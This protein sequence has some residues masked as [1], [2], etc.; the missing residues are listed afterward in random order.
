MGIENQC[1]VAKTRAAQQAAALKEQVNARAAEMKNNI[2]RAA[3]QANE[4][5]AYQE[6]TQKNMFNPYGYFGGSK[7]TD[8]K[9]KGGKDDKKKG[10][11]DD[12][13][14]DKGTQEKKKGDKGKKDKKK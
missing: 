7:G 9:K 8:D 6:Y 12:K 3:A 1:Q 13:K 11:K 4:M 5:K 14:K 2:S 10:G